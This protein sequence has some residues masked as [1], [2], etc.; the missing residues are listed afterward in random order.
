MSAAKAK[1]GLFIPTYN[2]EA[3]IEAVLDEIPEV[4]MDRLSAIYVIDNCSQDKTL[5][6]VI[7]HK[8]PAEYKEVKMQKLTS[9]EEQILAPLKS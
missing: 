5:E 4:V 8:V 6:K 9:G 1:V 2:V 3:S 7:V